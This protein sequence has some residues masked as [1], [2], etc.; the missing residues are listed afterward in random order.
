MWVAALNLRAT[1]ADQIALRKRLVRLANLKSGDT[2]IEIGLGTGALLCDLARAVGKGGK[3][4]GIEPQFVLAEAARARLED[5]NLSAVVKTESAETV[6]NKKRNSRGL[7]GADGFDS[8]AAG[9]SAKDSGR[10][11]CVS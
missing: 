2:A 3:V 1:A 10:K 8:F 7:S 5:E 9:R 4:F 11:W 6:I